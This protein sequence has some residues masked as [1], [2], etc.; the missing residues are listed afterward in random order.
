MSSRVQ[1]TADKLI[2]YDSLVNYVKTLSMLGESPSEI[3][4]DLIKHGYSKDMV[5]CSV[6]AILEVDESPIPRVVF[7]LL[8]FALVCAVIALM[9]GII[10][11]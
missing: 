2:N 7:Q 11:I 1:N 6:K 10:S 9:T 4:R 8:E 3:E 5:G